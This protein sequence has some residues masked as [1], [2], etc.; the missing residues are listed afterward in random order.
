MTNPASQP[1]E[2]LACHVYPAADFIA[3]ARAA[4]G[5]VLVHCTQVTIRAAPLVPPL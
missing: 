3:A 4:G 1:E 2:D 5:R